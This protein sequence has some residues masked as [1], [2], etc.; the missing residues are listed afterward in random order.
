MIKWHNKLTTSGDEMKVNKTM[1]RFMF[2][3]K[4]T[5]NQ[6]HQTQ[7]IAEFTTI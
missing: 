7:P 2:Y 6:L 1:K 3:K 4:K 5:L